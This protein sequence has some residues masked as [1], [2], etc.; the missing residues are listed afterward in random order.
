VLFE[1]L[2]GLLPPFAELHHRDV[3]Q[4]LSGTTDVEIS[5]VILAV[6]FHYITSHYIAS[7]EHCNMT[8]MMVQGK[9]VQVQYVCSE[10]IGVVFLVLVHRVL[11]QC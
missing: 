8:N 5:V 9:E 4:V 10:C 2:L 11:A 1:P 6:T 3:V 7:L